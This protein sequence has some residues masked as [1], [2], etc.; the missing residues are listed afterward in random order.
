[1]TRPN[2][3]LIIGLDYAGKSSILNVLHRKYNLMDNIKP[4]AGIER[5]NITILGIPIVTWDLG[6]Q[7]KFRNQYLN[8][9]KYF[10]KTDSVFYVIDALNARRFELSTQYFTDI[11]NIFKKLDI[12]P[13]IVVCLH[14][15]DPNIYN[16]PETQQLI[17]DLREIILTKTLGFEISIHITSIYDMKSIVR[18]FSE[19]LQGLISA[20]QPF[21]KVL[22]AIAIQLNLDG[23]ILFEQNLLIV[24]EYYQN[25]ICEERCLNMAYNSIFYMRSTNPQL[26][27]DTNFAKNFEFILNLRNKE[28]RFRF[29]EVHFKNWD[30]FM[31][32]IGKEKIDRTRINDILNS[33]SSIFN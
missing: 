33:M 14:K 2:K 19:S 21:K 11:L 10:D 7:E 1:M 31:L 8:N 16:D 32:T 22:E 13:K 6:G 30:L 27:D 12:K 24:G 23:V 15:I 9:I 18:A 26:I 4:T 28:R 20:L 5:E 25:A 29:F 3:I 17:T